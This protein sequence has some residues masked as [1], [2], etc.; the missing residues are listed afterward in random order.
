MT[1]TLTE[2]DIE[3]AALAWLHGFGWQVA[4]GPPIAPGT[5]NAERDDYVA[6]VLDRRLRRCGYSPKAL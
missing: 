1:T 3:Q 6:T 5:P 4:H 2:A